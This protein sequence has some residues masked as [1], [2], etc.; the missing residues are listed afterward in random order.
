MSFIKDFFMNNVVVAAPVP[1]IISP[2]EKQESGNKILEDLVD[3]VVGTV[4][5]SSSPVRMP[6][7]VTANN[8]L[9]SNLIQYAL[10][11]KDGDPQKIIVNSKIAL[12]LN[13]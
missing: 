10:T 8:D 4:C 9:L 12:L 6:G 13:N 7:K 5:E 3:V 1:K 2:T 11:L